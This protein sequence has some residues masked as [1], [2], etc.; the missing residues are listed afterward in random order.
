MVHAFIFWMPIYEQHVELSLQT[1]G[2]HPAHHRV[3]VAMLS[4]DF[5]SA[6]CRAS[7]KSDGIVTMVHFSATAC[8]NFAPST[9]YKPEK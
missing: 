9:K 6:S 2:V 7:N 4:R 3:C 1:R 5:V 8:P